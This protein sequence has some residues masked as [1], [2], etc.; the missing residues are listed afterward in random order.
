MVLITA[1]MS[2]EAYSCE[3]LDL[4][5]AKIEYTHV[6]RGMP[7]EGTTVSG[8]TYNKAYKPYKIDGILIN[9][10]TL[11]NVT[12]VYQPNVA[13]LIWIY[14]PASL[15][16]KKGGPP[17][18]T[19]KKNDGLELGTEYLIFGTFKKGLPGG[20]Y[21]TGLCDYLPYSSNM[22]SKGYDA[23]NT[24]PKTNVI[25]INKEKHKYD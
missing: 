13:D 2:S 3:L 18:I 21:I 12:S 17:Y 25:I 7:L 9:D 16:L 19:A 4:E 24:P 5:Q 15:G 8:Q 1:L 14:H 10:R 23:G 22:S 6:L 20:F 11:F